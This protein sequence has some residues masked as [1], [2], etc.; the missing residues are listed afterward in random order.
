MAANLQGVKVN[1]RWQ[2]FRI[3][4]HR[5]FARPFLTVNQLF[6]RLSQGVVNNQLY[7]NLGLTA[8]FKPVANGSGVTGGLVFLAE[9]IGIVLR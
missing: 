3:K 5:M 2:V 9:R 7:R 1:S 8:G 4:H 6:N